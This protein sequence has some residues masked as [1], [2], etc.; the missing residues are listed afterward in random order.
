MSATRPPEGAAALLGGLADAVPHL[1]WVASADGIVREYSG[2]ISNYAAARGTSGDGWRW[3]SMV[4]PD[5]LAA[6]EAAW[7]AA[8]ATRTEYEHEHRLLMADGTWRWHLSRGIVVA[9]PGDG[10]DDDDADGE[11]DHGSGH[12]QWYGTATD[13]HAVRDAEEQLRRTQS[14]LALAMRGGQI[15]WWQ[16]D[17]LT[18]EVVWSPELEELFGLP[19][20]TFAGD[21]G[22]FLALVHPDDRAAVTAAVG[23][24]LADGDDYVVEFR[25]QHA[26]G[27]L[28]WMEGRGRA[29]YEGGR[30]TF[31]HGIGMDITD[32]KVAEELVRAR[33]ERLRL[34]AEVGEFGLYDYDLV[35][36]GM[37]WSPELHAILGTDGRATAPEDAGIHPD[38]R[39]RTL[40]LFTAAQAP[41]SDGSFDFEYRML[42]PDGG[43]RWVSTHGQTY[44]SDGPPAERR[45]LRSIGVVV[46]VTERRQ[47][48]ELRDVFVSMLSHELRT[49]VTAIYGG[50]QVL[51]REHVD[52]AT[53]QEIISDIISESER[54]ERLVENLLVLARAERHAV[55]A[56]SDPV[57]IRPILSRVLAD[58]RRRWPGSVL[59]EAVEPGLPPVIG[60]EASVELILRNLISNALKYGAPGGTITISAVR[61]GDKLEVRVLDEGTGIDTADAG[62]LFDLFFRADGARRRA[63]GA[64]IGLFV[65]RVLTESSG[66]RVWARNRPEGGAEFGFALPIY[67]EA[68]DGPLAD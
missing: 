31:L 57:L 25:F 26:D 27:S 11:P 15:G 38:D 35:G 33:E 65:V 12:V 3:Q 58:K 17:L 62:R 53:R 9:T 36:G 8:L 54:L 4:H 5:D 50:S 49:P 22:A 16:R 55:V 23:G 7:T 66:G 20:G 48:D 40:A 43:V 34:A 32:R 56:G 28:R 18:E 6:T 64:G 29:T 21:E 44:F 14:A 37:Y 67:D 46:D 63:P 60:D 13:I 61:A 1:V 10:D 41:D 30:A 19:A 47:A 45:P 42:R 52:E 24:A 51:R 68:D 59:E 2:R 39:D